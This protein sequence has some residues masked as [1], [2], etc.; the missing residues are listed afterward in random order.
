M[1]ITAKEFI[2]NMGLGWNLGNTYE[3]A[4]SII[5]RLQFKQSYNLAIILKYGETTKVLVEKQIGYSQFNLATTLPSSLTATENA[6]IFLKLTNTNLITTEDLPVVTLNSSLTLSDGTKL[7]TSNSTGDIEFSKFV[8]SI[9]TYE[10]NINKKVNEL[11]S[12]KIAISGI[13]KNFPESTDEGA[14]ARV[15]SIIPTSWGTPRTTTAMLD[16][17]KSAGF[18]TI[19]IPITWKD[20]ID[21]TTYKVDKEWFDEIKKTIDYCVYTLKLYTIINVHHDDNENMNGWLFSDTF[22]TDTE[23]QLKYRTL[24]EDIATEFAD[25]PENLIFAGYN[26]TRGSDHSWDTKVSE[27]LYGIQ[28]IAEIFYETV[29]AIPGNETRILV[30]PTYA[31]KVYAITQ[32]FTDNNGNTMS[33]SIPNDNY[34][35]AEVHIYTGDLSTIRKDINKVASKNIPTFIGEFGIN[36]SNM[37]DSSIG[38]NQQYMVGYARYK[39]IGAILW[40][41]YG[42]MG[43]LIRNKINSSNYSSASVWRGSE[44]EFVP[45]LV[46]SSNLRIVPYTTA[47]RRTTA[48]TGDTLELFLHSDYDSVFSVETGSSS[49]TILSGN[50]TFLAGSKG[51]SSILGLTCNGEYNVFDITV[52]EPTKLITTTYNIDTTGIL[53]NKV[54]NQWNETN[55][56]WD[57]NASYYSLPSLIQVPP[58]ST[59]VNNSNKP[60]FVVEYKKSSGSLI[61][62]GYTLVDIKKG[63]SRVL[64]P[65]TNYIGISI[66][67]YKPENADNYILSY[68]IVDRDYD[69]EEYPTEN[70]ELSLIDFTKYKFSIY[71]TFDALGNVLYKL[72]LGRDDIFAK[73][74]ELDINDV[75]LRSYDCKNLENFTTHSFTSKLKIDLYA[76]FSY[77][78]FVEIFRNKTFNPK[79]EYVD[80]LDFPLLD[81]DAECPNISSYGV[82]LCNSKIRT[83]NGKIAKY[84]NKFVY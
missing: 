45:K 50:T 81:S 40:D 31:S 16:A 26:E 29:R 60:L 33:F 10:F 38:R 51:A 37:S 56:L 41:D 64:S 3:C 58:S 25:Y 19:R 8:D 55:G 74:T 22:I 63:E 69:Y 2:Q 65:N 7:D 13:I 5:D 6:T 21:S 52:T 39:G 47:T 57:N 35:A 80:Y 61:N 73:I 59:F 66:S 71:R 83:V 18:K 62:L 84:N 4:F 82:E 24:W 36:A 43:C 54:Y 42:S 49:G 34:C 48:I 28:K 46:N 75:E 12:A 67:Q 27:N 14:K 70:K 30:F 44:V 76:D 78:E 17:V 53:K 1:A 11:A 72:N 15:A 77:S 23:M 79:L 20:H 32:S 68:D 9:S